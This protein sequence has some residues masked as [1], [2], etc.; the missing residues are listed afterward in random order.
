MKITKLTHSC[1][2]VEMPKRT[3]LF[4]PGD[5][6]TVNIDT[7]QYLDDIFITHN[8]ADH[9]DVPTIKKLVDKFPNVRIFGP[10]QA[11]EQLESE[12]IKA[13]A[14]QPEGVIVFSAPHAPLFGGMTAPDNIG[15]HYLDL[16]SNPGDSHEFSE[17][18][19]ILAMPMTAPWGYMVQAV[20]KIREL[21]PQYVI[22]IHDWHWRDEARDK[23]YE[24]IQ[25]MLAEDG[26]TFI[27]PK[28]GETFNVDVS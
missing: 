19:K 7:L 13:T 18:K 17:S 23:F 26:I 4:D 9:M 11:E 14:D 5:V 16:L 3:V 27:V 1:L 10:E 8:H 25:V 21:K 24:R 28:N 12:G 20:A 6:S 2:L 15:I 22:P